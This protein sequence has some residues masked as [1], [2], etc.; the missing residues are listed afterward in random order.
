MALKAHD[1][2]ELEIPELRER[3]EGLRTKLFDLRSRQARKELEG[4]VEIRNVRRDLSRV[5]TLLNERI[6]R[7]AAAEKR[8]T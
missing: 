8:S 7:N 4:G 5:L 6:R 3:A 1:L 2:R